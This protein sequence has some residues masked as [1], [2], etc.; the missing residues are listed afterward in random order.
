MNDSK[1]EFAKESASFD[2]VINAQKKISQII[3]NPV[4][5][6]EEKEV[7]KYTGKS[8]VNFVANYKNRCKELGTEME[9]I[10]EKMYIK[11]D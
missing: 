2:V 6:A 11:I 7:S 3:L 4:Y 5:I 8:F 10:D 9:I 1:T